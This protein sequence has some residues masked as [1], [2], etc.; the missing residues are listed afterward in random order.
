MYVR[1][2]WINTNCRSKSSYATIVCTVGGWQQCTLFGHLW[3]QSLAL[4]NKFGVRL[5]CTNDFIE[6]SNVYLTVWLILSVDCKV[7]TDEHP[8]PKWS[9]HVLW[10]ANAATSVGRVLNHVLFSSKM[11]SLSWLPGL[12]SMRSSS[13]QPIG[14]LVPVKP[15]FKV[16]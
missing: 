15:S 13:S 10:P 2:A 7:F 14:S 16:G 8:R 1:V 9:E 6:A 12:I 5:C 3:R 4:S 11:V